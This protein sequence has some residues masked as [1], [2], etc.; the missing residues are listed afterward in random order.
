[1]TKTLKV[2]TPGKIGSLELRNRTIRSGCFE[3]MCPDATPNDTL[4]EHHR[5]V[6]EGGI[7]MTTVA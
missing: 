5:Q 1:E 4:M 2:F 3:G 7:G 6:A